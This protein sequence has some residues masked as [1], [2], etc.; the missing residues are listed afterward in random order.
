MDGIFCQLLPPR[1]VV[2][3]ICLMLHSLFWGRKDKANRRVGQAAAAATNIVTIMAF[4][5]CLFKDWCTVTS[6]PS[7][8]PRRK[9]NLIWQGRERYWALEGFEVNEIQSKVIDAFVQSNRTNEWCRRIISS[10]QSSKDNRYDHLCSSKQGC[11]FVSTSGRH[12]VRTLTV[13]ARQGARR[14]MLLVQV[15]FIFFLPTV[16]CS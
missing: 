5:F 15:F 9:E 12:V 7:S 8:G 1:F 6:T 2:H 3:L 16:F 11:V 13:C 10:S 4:L 14:S